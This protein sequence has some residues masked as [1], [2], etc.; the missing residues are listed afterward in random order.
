MLHLLWYIIV[1]FIAG[2]VAKSVLH[3]NMTLFW[4]F[5]FGLVASIVGGFIVHLF[6]RPKPESN[7]HPSGIIV[8]IIFALLMLWLLSKVPVF[9]AHNI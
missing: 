9:S 6:D 5:L 7:Y 1:G 3:L 2:F 8:S 4:T